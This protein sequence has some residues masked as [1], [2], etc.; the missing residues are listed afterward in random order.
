MRK[1]DTTNKTW[2]QKTF[3]IHS[4]IINLYKYLEFFAMR[5][6][7][8][9]DILFETIAIFSLEYIESEMA[10]YKF[11]YR[12]DLEKM[13]KDVVRE[14]KGFTMTESTLDR[15]ETFFVSN[16]PYKKGES[17]EIL[18]AL[19][20][21]KHLENYELENLNIYIKFDDLRSE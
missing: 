11:N 14:V 2:L 6:S 16:K 9:K 1:K 15:L 10:S 21:V 3:R 4:E 17:I 20:A 18:I 8:S 12:F 19:Y 13:G 7:I 5:N